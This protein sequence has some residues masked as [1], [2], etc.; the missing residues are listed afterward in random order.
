MTTEELH[1]LRMFCLSLVAGNREGWNP[2]DIVVLAKILEDYIL[3][4]PDE[5]NSPTD[6]P[7]SPAN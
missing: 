7:N 3:G 6:E 1:E 4:L 5:P 2:E